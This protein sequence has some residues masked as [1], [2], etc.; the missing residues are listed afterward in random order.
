MGEANE[1]ISWSVSQKR[2]SDS[3]K[4]F[5][6]LRGPMKRKNLMKLA[7]DP[8]DVCISVSAYK[9]VIVQRYKTLH[10]KFHDY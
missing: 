9:C 1:I 8:C 6:Q 2:S 7:T 5:L 4:S 3:F 10:Q